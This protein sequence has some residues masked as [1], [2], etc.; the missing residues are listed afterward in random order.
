MSILIFD[1][2]L[3]EYTNEYENA[4]EY[5]MSMPFYDEYKQ[6]TKRVLHE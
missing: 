5:R 3:Y 1:E 6:N 4:H 2:Y